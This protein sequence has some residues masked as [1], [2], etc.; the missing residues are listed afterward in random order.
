MSEQPD[1]SSSAAP[2]AAP[3]RLSR[4]ERRARLL[5]LVGTILLLAGIALGVTDDDIGRWL[6]IGGIVT[7]FVA[8]HRFGRLGAGGS[9][10]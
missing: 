6:M 4:D 5:I 10:A 1:S 2:A 7:L 3:A 9:P 8:L